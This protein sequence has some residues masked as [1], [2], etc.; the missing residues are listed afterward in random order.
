M[1][2][3]ASFGTVSK[4]RLPL[5]CENDKVT[6][7]EREKGGILAIPE[8]ES[9][10]WRFVD[11]HTIDTILGELHSPSTLTI[12]LTFLDIF[13]VHLIRLFM[14]LVLRLQYRVIGCSFHELLVEL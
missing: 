2:W 10:R 3:Y 14:F 7:G 4:P 9:V 12:L 11:I 8:P 6:Q 13:Q 1:L 5:V